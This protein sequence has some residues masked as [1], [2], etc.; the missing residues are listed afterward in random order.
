MFPKFLAGLV[1]AAV[2]QVF[3]V[4]ADKLENDDVYCS[5]LQVAAFT[6]Q[7][8]YMKNHPNDPQNDATAQKDLKD[9]KDIMSGAQTC[10][11]NTW[12]EYKAFA[13]SKGYYPQ[14]KDRGFKSQ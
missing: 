10:Y 12:L 9:V 11:D 4:T 2:T 5:K 1:L 14:D 13:E 3:P 7:V 8:E 6:A